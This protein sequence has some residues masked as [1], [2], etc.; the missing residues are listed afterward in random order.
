AMLEDMAILTGGQ[1]VSEEIGLKLEN[2][3]IDMLG[4]ARKVV[5]TRDETTIVEG[6]GKG[7]DIKARINQIRNEIENTDS[8]WDREKLQERLG[9]KCRGGRLPRAG[10]GRA[11]GRAGER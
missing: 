8:D 6:S 2:I 11:G 9:E 10:G 1:V 5:V 7:A 3:D 4:R